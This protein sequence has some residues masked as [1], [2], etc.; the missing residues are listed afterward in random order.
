ME[1]LLVEGGSTGGE[2]RQGATGRGAEEDGQTAQECMTLCR[3]CC[4]LRRVVFLF[5]GPKQCI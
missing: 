4:L 1:A 3:H 5:P 2:A